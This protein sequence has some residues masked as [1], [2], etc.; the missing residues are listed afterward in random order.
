[1]EYIVSGRDDL[2]EQSQQKKWRAADE[3][4]HRQHHQRPVLRHDRLV[5]IKLIVG[6]ETSYEKTKPRSS[7][8]QQTEK[9]QRPRR[10]IQQ[11][12]D[13]Q[14]IQEH[15]DRPPDSVVGL[16]ALPAA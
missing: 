2:T 11:E 12:F 15:P 10:I 7:H 1:M 6:E 13:D 3:Q 9:L 16:P 14:Q 4:G 8:A 5:Q